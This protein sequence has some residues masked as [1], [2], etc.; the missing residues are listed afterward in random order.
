MQ[1]IVKFYLSCVCGVIPNPQKTM[2][3]YANP[4]VMHKKYRG[5][6]SLEQVVCIY[7][8]S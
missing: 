5:Y 3:L 2:L 6:V 7:V 1:L 4:I 8:N